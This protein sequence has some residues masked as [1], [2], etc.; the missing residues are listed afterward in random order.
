MIESLQALLFKIAV[1]CFG[2]HVVLT[3]LLGLRVRS[4]LAL[5]DGLFSVP[6]WRAGHRSAVALM[7]VKFFW[8]FVAEPSQLRS[9]GSFARGLFWSARLAGTTFVAVVA[10]FFLGMFFGAAQ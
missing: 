6:A 9:H 3:V 10:L 7:R 2:V 1:A 8:P 5:A 4:D